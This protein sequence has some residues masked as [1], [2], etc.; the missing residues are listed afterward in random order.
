MRRK[1]QMMIRRI[2]IDRSWDMVGRSQKGRVNSWGGIYK[3]EFSQVHQGEPWYLD[4]KWDDEEAKKPFYRNS[5]V[6]P[7]DSHQTM[8]EAA[9]LIEGSCLQSG[10]SVRYLW[11]WVIESLLYQIIAQDISSFHHRLFA[12]QANTWQNKEN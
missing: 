5:S 6:N 9:S 3:S 10:R 11:L 7:E 1:F 8:A 4:L 12:T 2:Y